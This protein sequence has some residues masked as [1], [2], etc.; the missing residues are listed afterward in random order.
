MP[1]LSLYLNDRAMGVLKEE[2][3]KEKRSVSSFVSE[4][5]MERKAKASWPADYWNDVYGC[6][7]DDSFRV[8]DEVDAALDG[9]L[10]TFS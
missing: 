6:L 8:P 10:P 9:P 2:A 3:A 7:D 4:L 5:I 1:Q